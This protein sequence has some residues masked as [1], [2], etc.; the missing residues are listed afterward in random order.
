MIV[1]VLLLL[2]WFM[3]IVFTS[4]LLRDIVASA[5]ALF[6][7]SHFGD[8]GNPDIGSLN[9]WL[10][11]PSAFVDAAALVMTLVTLTQ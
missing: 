9:I 3:A 8:N 6:F 11:I 4:Y 7:A 10:V 5:I 2:M 1:W